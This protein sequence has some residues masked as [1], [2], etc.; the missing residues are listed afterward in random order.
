ME[1][2]LLGEEEHFEKLLK[3]RRYEGP[4]GDLAERIISA[5]V[6]KK[7]KASNTIAVFLSDLLWELNLPKPALTVV[8][9]LLCLALI[10]GFTIGSSGLSRYV[11][12]EQYQTNLEEFLYYEGEVL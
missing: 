11:S 7:K 10:V 9:V 8:S 6:C 1:D 12:A 5:S 4:S 3:S 2:M